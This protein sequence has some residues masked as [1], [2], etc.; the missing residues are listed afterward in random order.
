MLP[1]LRLLLLLLLLLPAP[2]L[3]LLFLALF[4]LWRPDDAAEGSKGS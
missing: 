2:L 3:F 4:D 1:L